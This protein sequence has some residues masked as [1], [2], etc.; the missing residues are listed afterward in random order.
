MEGRVIDYQE[1]QD[2]QGIFFNENTFFNFVQDI[3]D[4]YYLLLTES[5]EENIQNTQYS[6]LLNIQLTEY[7][8]KFSPPPIF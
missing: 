3:E 6:Y 5:D 8:P 7:I 1:V 4:N 2:L